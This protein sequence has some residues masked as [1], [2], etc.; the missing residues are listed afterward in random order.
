[1]HNK[2]GDFS[3]SSSYWLACQTQKADLIREA[4]CLSSLNGLK[5]QVWSLA[6]PPKI[7]N[8][9]WRV[10]SGIVP[11]ADLIASRGLKVDSMCQIC[12]L[13][14]K[15]INHVLFLCSLA[16]QM[17]ALSIYHNPVCGFNSASVYENVHSLL[18]N[19][20]NKNIPL[21]IRKSFLWILWYLW[22]NRNSLC[23]EGKRFLSSDTVDKVTDEAVFWF[24]AQEIKL[25]AQNQQGLNGVK[26]H[27]KWMLPPDPWLK[28]NSGISWSKEKLVIGGS[29]LLRDGRGEVLLHSIRVLQMWSL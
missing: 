11:V 27:I 15:S 1:M 26:E 22:K 16:R 6:A 7:K 9:L 29:W 13:E 21:E 14:G 25:T 3:V 20:R 8:F 17:W 19:L 2:S 18:V 28:C 24:Q 12:G 5:N 10:V 4:E 23:F